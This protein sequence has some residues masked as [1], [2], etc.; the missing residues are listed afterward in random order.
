MFG[1]ATFVDYLL[2][3]VD[4]ARHAQPIARTQL[5][6]S[7]KGFGY[8]LRSNVAPEAIRLGKSGM[9]GGHRAWEFFE[10]HVFPFVSTEVRERGKGGTFVEE[11]GRV[12]IDGRMG[13]GHCWF[14]YTLVFIASELVE[15]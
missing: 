6:P 3:V 15:L 2:E 11:K 7:D 1:S 4:V 5:I 10:S 13:G 9:H 8:A 12:A 14:L